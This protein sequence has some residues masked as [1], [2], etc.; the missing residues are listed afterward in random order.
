MNNGYKHQFAN[1]E[2]QV[3]ATR[4][5]RTREHIIA[6]LSTNYVEYLILVNGF[7]VERVE[8]D[9]GYDLIMFT[10]DDH[11]EIENGQIYLQ[12]KATD[13]VHL[14]NHQY[15]ASPVSTKAL[16]LWRNEL[17]PVFFILY[18]AVP[19]MAYWLY[20]QAYFEKHPN[21]YDLKQKYFTLQIPIANLFTED[22][23]R[24]F[25]EYKITLLTQLSG[26]AQYHV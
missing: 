1:N 19:K 13:N 14:V 9:Y 10:Y 3:M 18:D 25:R 2:K 7:S 15:V 17:L 4:K 11:G 20:I 16:N 12:L 22:T 26:K 23:I 6:D 5:K 8:K 24:K 21:Q